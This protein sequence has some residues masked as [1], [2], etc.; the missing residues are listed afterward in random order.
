M[1]SFRLI[2]PI[3]N[4][5][6]LLRIVFLSMICW[7]FSI[8]I[9]AQPIVETS[10]FTLRSLDNVQVITHAGDERLFVALKSGVVLVVLED[11][12]ILDE[13]FLDLSSRIAD[14]T[15]MSI[16]GLAFHPNFAENGLFYIYYSKPN[17]ARILSSFEINDRAENR[18]EPKSEKIILIYNQPIHIMRGGDIQFGTDGYLYIATA[19]AGDHLDP[20]H[21]AQNGESFLGKLL[22]IN[23]KENGE[24]TIPPDNPYVNDPKVL[25]EIYAFG[26]HDPGKLGFDQTTG[27]LWIPDSGDQFAEEINRLT[28]YSL[29]NFNFG[30]PCYEGSV[31]VGLSLCKERDQY[32]SP[33]IEYSHAVEGNQIVG[34][35]VY[36][37][38]RYPAIWGNY[39][40]A[41]RGAG[42]FFR[43][44]EGD[45]GWEVY[46]LPDIV[47]NDPQTFGKDAY[48][49]IYV[50][51]AATG[52]IYKIIEFCQ[53][54]QPYL[55]IIDNGVIL[56]ELESAFW[57]GNF[58]VDW[59]LDDLLIEEPV[60]SLLYSEFSGRYQVN[61][62]H[63]RGCFMESQPLKVMTYMPSLNWAENIHLWPNPFTTSFT[64]EWRAELELDAVIID[65]EGRQVDSQV[66]PPNSRMTW[67]TNLPRGI[68]TIQLVASN[69]SQHTQQIVRK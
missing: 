66:I 57:S 44:F 55:S 1:V 47:V 8:R 41:D 35:V 16:T 34:G 19:D 13:P 37:G 48:G 17:G 38:E 6:M 61:L 43:A 54:Y 23:V 33:I 64:L 65:S 60:D 5:Y 30:W 25:D 20:I 68:Y 14:S 2:S 39:I 9:I 42:T 49:E 46:E 22:R 3:K 59:Y 45:E 52:L 50:Y 40:F 32:A 53:A 7:I 4:Q 24:Y 29:D 69:G 63:D 21:M 26:L 15:L 12:T 51:S 18:A 56:M 27:A 10:P 58:Q 36:R 67:N 11:G 62:T 28:P 31:N